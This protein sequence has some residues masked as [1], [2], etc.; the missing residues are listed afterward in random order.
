MRKVLCV[1]VIGLAATAVFAA[2]DKFQPLNVKPGLWEVTETRT[3]SGAPP[4][5]PEMQARMEKMTPAQ[6]AKLEAAM[7]REYGGGPK[8]TTYKKCVKKE[9]VEK[10]PFAG[11]DEKCN[12][13]VLNSSSS[14]LEVQGTSC[15]AGKD[16]GMQTD[17]EMKIHVVDRENVQ[18]SAKAKSTGNGQT[19]N[20]NGTATGKWL[21][22]ICP[23]GSE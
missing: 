21:G 6:R 12:W 5:T 14:D 11:P 9:E 22:A 16:Q 8:T 20:V 17:I 13:T 3:T 4:M 7:Q 18:G 19:L 23:A 1:G 2:N 10:N 15:E